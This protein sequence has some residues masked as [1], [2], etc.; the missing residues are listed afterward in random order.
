VSVATPKDPEA[1]K[2]HALA[3]ADAA[4]AC[5]TKL[6]TLMDDLDAEWQQIL[7]P[8]WTFLDQLPEG[9]ARR[10]LTS[11]LFISHLGGL[12]PLH[13]LVH[14]MLRIALLPRPDLLNRLCALAIARRPGVLR[15]CIDRQVRDSMRQALLDMFDPLMQ[16]SRQGRPVD[17]ATASWSPIIWACV[18]YVDWQQTRPR[19]EDVRV[20]QLVRL[21]L[22]K[23]MLE[24][25]S[26][27]NPVPAEKSTEQ[28]LAALKDMGVVWS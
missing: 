7:K 17:E 1:V 6:G 22:P 3:L 5:E 20:H 12:L 24:G 27:Q 26:G 21:S 19:A 2:V 23:R 8:Q 9:P 10:S 15:S 16:L 28:A 13:R 18:G 25:I 14:P 4:R 11:R